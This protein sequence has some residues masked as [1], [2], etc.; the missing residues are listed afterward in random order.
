MFRKGHSK[1]PTQVLPY[2]SLLAPVQPEEVMAQIKEIFDPVIL[3]L[4]N[5]IRGYIDAW[6][7]ISPPMIRWRGIYPCSETS[8]AQ[9]ESLLTFQNTTHVQK[10]H[11]KS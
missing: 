7:L 5:R 9:K 1:K 3:R 10:Y 11:I 4:F 8:L 2:V 6:N